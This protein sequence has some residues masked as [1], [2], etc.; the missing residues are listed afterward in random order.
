MLE[1]SLSLAIFLNN[2]QVQ[3]FLALTLQM[4][5]GKGDILLP[6]SLDF[7]HYFGVIP[8]FLACMLETV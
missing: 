7:G 1:Y 3:R 5:S 8:T 6:E 2:G 4:V